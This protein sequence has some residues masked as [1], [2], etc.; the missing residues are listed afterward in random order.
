VARTSTPDPALAAAIRRLREERH[1]TREGLAFQAGI[2]TG[3]LARIEL[4]RTTPGWDTVRLLVRALD[5]TLVELGAMV[6]GTAATPS[7]A[8][9]PA[10][11]RSAGDTDPPGGRLAVSA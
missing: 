9:A 4:G 8:S 6:E 7:A 10:P 5:I 2:T 11:G 1:V 3:A